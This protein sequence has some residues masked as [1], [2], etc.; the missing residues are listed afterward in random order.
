MF[1]FDETINR[2]N[3]DSTKWDFN[4][5]PENVIPMPVADM[6]FRCP[7]PIIKAMLEVAEHGVMGYSFVPKELKTLFTQRMKDLYDW[8]IQEEWQVWIPGLVPGITTSYKAV[9]QSGDEVM[10]TIPVY[11][12]FHLAP[13]WADRQLVT[14]PLLL[15]G[16]RWV[17]DFEAIEK[18]MTPRTKV[19]ML[20]NPYNP[21][22][23]VFTPTELTKLVE[24][25]Q[26]HN[27]VICSDEIHC[28]L[29]LEENLRHTPTA[30]L[31]P[32]AAQMTITLMAPS[33]TFNI[34]GLGCSVAIIPNKE[35]RDKFI[36]AKAGVFPELN[37]FGIRA[38]Y[39]AYKDCE[40]WRKELVKYLKTN[41]D[42]LHNAMNAIQG[43][44]MNKLEATYLAWIDARGTG[45]ENLAE[46]LLKHGI[47]VVDGPVFKGQGFFRVNFGCTR[48]TL[49]EGIKRIQEAFAAEI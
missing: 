41:H 12:P 16:E 1:N 7:E 9:G 40:P 11:G 48:A 3:T 37:R 20:C 38:A 27:V 24:I 14:V 2:H 43:L 5:D 10:T 35:L 34:A 23:T 6:D 31:S 8:E 33:K 22:G 21:G 42:I 15:E 17:M 46:H 39:A 28:D 25:C 36:F 44:K 29:I 19:F 18:A 49:E 32:E 30:S 45:I 26:R 13:N 47:R 4:N